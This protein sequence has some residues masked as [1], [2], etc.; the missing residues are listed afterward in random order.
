MKFLKISRCIYL[1]D[2]RSCKTL[3][4]HEIKDYIHSILNTKQK[5]TDVVCMKNFTDVYLDRKKI[6]Y[7]A[8]KLARARVKN[9]MSNVFN[10]PFYGEIEYE[11]RNIFGGIR[12][13]VLYDGYELQKIFCE[14]IPDNRFKSIHIIFTGRLIGTF[15]NSDGRYHSH[16]ILCGHPTI[17]ST[18][19]IVEA[20]AKSREY[21]QTK[22]KLMRISLPIEIAKENFKGMF[23]DYNDERMTEI[24]KGYV[25]QAIMYA[26]SGAPFCKDKKCRLYNSRY[27]RDVLYA[28]LTKPD[29]CSYHEKILTNITEAKF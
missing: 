11:K 10:T 12:A 7:F 8:E 27:Q 24:M 26:V 14:M 9:P 22:Y 6:N 20:P 23:I 2:D 3:R 15:N 19:G 5:I 16:V 4:I 18:N 1:Y 17:I 21:Y 28:Q 29:F 13:S 25:M